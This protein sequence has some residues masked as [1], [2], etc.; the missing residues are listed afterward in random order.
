M[1]SKDAIQLTRMSSATPVKEMARLLAG[2]TTE[3]NADT[4]TEA[5]AASGAKP[6]GKTVNPPGGP[7]Q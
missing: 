6:G 4:W 2:K 1:V 7:V 3:K 5:F